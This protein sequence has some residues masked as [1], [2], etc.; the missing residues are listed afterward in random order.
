MGRCANKNGPAKAFSQFEIASYRDLINHEDWLT[1][2][3]WC[4]LWGSRSQIAKFKTRQLKNLMFWLK[5]PN[6]MPTN[7]S[8]YTVSPARSTI[9]EEATV[10]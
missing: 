3:W 7:F 5:S 1:S 6:L 9:T 4:H 8:H 10:H 2:Q